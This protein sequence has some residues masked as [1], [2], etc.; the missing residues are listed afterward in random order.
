MFVT[1]EVRIKETRAKGEREFGVGQKQ[2][3]GETRVED[4][5]RTYYSR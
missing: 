4:E 1:G 5:M 2:G 3:K